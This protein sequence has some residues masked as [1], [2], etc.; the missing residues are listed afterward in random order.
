MCQNIF[1][2]KERQEYL[3]RIKPK[4]PRKGL[5]K[6]RHMVANILFDVERGWYKVSEFVVRFNKEN[7][8]NEKFAL[9]EYLRN[10]RND[11]DDPESPLAFDVCTPEEAKALQAAEKAAKEA[12]IAKAE[13]PN[14]VDLMESERS[15]TPIAREAPPAKPKR[16]RGRP[17]KAP[18]VAPV[19]DA[20]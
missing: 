19:A 2:S 5:K 6:G 7:Q 11:N 17:P 1:M 20:E 9:I 18:K 13:N 8:T 10:V 14:P 16:P 4:N 3:V 12:A 15:E